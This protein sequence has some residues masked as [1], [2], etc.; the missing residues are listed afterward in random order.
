[1]G[2]CASGYRSTAD[3]V[4]NGVDLSSKT[5]V[6]TGPTS[7]IG[8]E[9]ARVLAQRKCQRL[10]LAARDEKRLAV[11]CEQLKKETGN[12]NIV[13]MALNLSSFKSIREFAAKYKEAGYPL[14]VLICNAGCMATPYKKTE[15]GLEMQIGTNH[16]GHQYLTTL[17]MDVMEKSA[18]ARVVV[19]ASNLHKG[20]TINFEN[21][22]FPSEANYAKW[23][24][25]QQSKLMNVLFAKELAR[26]GAEKKITA[27]SLHPGIIV[28]EIG[29]DVGCGYCLM[30][31]CCHFCLKSVPQGAATTVYLAVAPGVEDKS[32]QYFENCHNTLPD[33]PGQSDE[34]AKRLWETTEK[35][36][37]SKEEKKA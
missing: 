8:L 15:E 36:I 7:G 26:R 37:A 4:S 14:N 24:Q 13:G 3:A 2:C 12:Q 25:Y 9:T 11:V 20:P 28:T 33:P 6:V 18:P 19:V 22:P 5:I 29:R 23:G 31:C 30:S 34:L 27:Y 1:M 17:L 21:I 16:F 35:F 10:V 32:G